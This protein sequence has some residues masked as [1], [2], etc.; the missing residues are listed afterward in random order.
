M[1]LTA[2]T[3]VNSGVW[4][5]TNGSLN[6]RFDENDAKETK[7]RSGEAKSRWLVGWITQLLSLFKVVQA[8]GSVTK[9]SRRMT[10]LSLVRTMPMF[11]E[12]F[13]SDTFVESPQRGTNGHPLELLYRYRS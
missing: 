1:F 8:Y 6:S 4:T 7:F 2:P 11:I 13:L 5:I 3:L 9:K 10:P 12:S